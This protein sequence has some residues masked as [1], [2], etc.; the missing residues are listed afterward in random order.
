MIRKAIRSVKW[1]DK[2]QLGEY[3]LKNRIVMGAMTRQRCNP[4]DGIPNELLVEY[5]TQRSGAGLILT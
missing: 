4:N 2:V 5:Y 1:N 3:I